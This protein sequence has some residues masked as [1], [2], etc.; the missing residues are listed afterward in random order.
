[1]A[2]LISA[3]LTSDKLCTL[4]Y[5]TTD[6]KMLS[7]HEEAF[8]AKIISHTYSDKGIVV[9]EKPIT[10]IGKSAFSNVHTLLS[11]TIPNG[12]TWIGEFAFYH[13]SSLKEIYCKPTN[14]PELYAVDTGI[15]LPLKGFPFDLGVKIYVPFGSYHNYMPDSLYS[16]GNVFQQIWSRYEMYIEQY[17][18]KEQLFEKK[19]LIIPGS[20]DRIEDNSFAF[21]CCSEIIIE[22]GVKE[23]GG[24]AFAW[25]DA[26]RAY[27]PSSILKIEENPFPHSHI[28]NIT[29]KSPNYYVRD[30][31]LV[32]NETFRMVS[33]VGRDRYSGKSIFEL[34]VADNDTSR[35]F[36]Y[37]IPS[38]IKILGEGCFRGRQLDKIT[39]P[40]TVVTILQNPFVGCSA[41]IIN[42][43]P[44]YILN[45]GFLIE[46]ASKT[47]IAY[48]GKEKDIIIPDGIEIIEGSAFEMLE[49]GV[50]SIT[51]PS[52]INI[53]RDNFGEECE[54]QHIYVQKEK[55][56]FIQESLP[57]YKTIIS[58]IGTKDIETSSSKDDQCNSQNTQYKVK[59]N[60]VVKRETTMTYRT[61][62]MFLAFMNIIR[63]IIS[64]P[65]SI[66]ILGLSYIVIEWLI[67][68]FI[69]IYYYIAVWGTRYDHPPIFDWEHKFQNFKSFVCITCLSTLISAMISGLIGGK[70]CPKKHSVATACLF[71]AVILPIIIFSCVIFWDTE[72][73]FYSSVWVLDMI[74]MGF[75]F[76]GCA[77]AA[78]DN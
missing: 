3:D 33:Y 63:W 43:S 40:Q 1:M 61:N 49:Y 70:I 37:T 54:L 58:V 10:C 26:D 65:I 16:R 72:H 28:F 32:E 39:I 62:P 46:K 24:W 13:C 19:P 36:E 68:L 59:H 50:N 45:N 64:A 74:V 71:G 67:S 38:Y 48:V 57:R 2:K 56:E 20:T 21:K 42:Y 17:E 34:E 60:E 29:S 12:V 41:E 53:I 78:N 44:N 23:I 9:F 76:V 25:N 47:L 55:V 8:D 77:S 14:P 73:W 75:L 5:T 15:G 31:A 27:I 11:V 7:F 66:V 35:K 51:L 18:F 6:G 30:K 22:E 52:S 69:K 4:T